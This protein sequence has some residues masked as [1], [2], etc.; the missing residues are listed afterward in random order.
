MSAAREPV[1]FVLEVSSYPYRRLAKQASD[2][3]LLVYLEHGVV[4]EV[5]TLVLY[6]RGKRPTPSNLILPSEEGFSS[7]QVSWKD[8]PGMFQLLGGTK[9]MIKV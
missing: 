4:P 8:D 9:A 6:T 7:I 5:V 1:Y 2:V 3:A